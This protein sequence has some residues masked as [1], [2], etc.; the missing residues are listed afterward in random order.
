MSHSNRLLVIHME[1][2][3]AVE[4]PGTI[5]GTQEGTPTPTIAQTAIRNGTAT[6]TTNLI[7]SATGVKIV[8]AIVII[9]TETV[10]TTAA[11]P[12]GAI[13]AAA[14]VVTEDSVLSIN[15][16]AIIWAAMIAAAAQGA[17]LS[18]H[19]G[20][21]LSTRA[22]KRTSIVDT[23]NPLVLTPIWP[24]TSQNILRLI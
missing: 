11:A 2:P 13:Q 24:I 6:V 16:I 17:A 4:V 22:M 19:I 9:A 12:L 7:A 23:V 1:I 15:S 10:A 18:I 8:Q 3:E 14:A 21:P 5:T 20:S